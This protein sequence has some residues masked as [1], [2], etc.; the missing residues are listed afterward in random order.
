[1]SE[2]TT[3]INDIVTSIIDE[4]DE[5]PYDAQ[6]VAEEISEGE[7]KAPQVDFDADYEAAQQYSVSEIDRTEEGAK[8]A[9]AA[10]APKF[11]LK[12]PENERTEADST[13]DPSD[14]ME[15]AK[16]VNPLIEKQAE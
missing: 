11:E 2:S 6:Q 12:Q 7:I 4:K 10:T 13:G 1:M 8:A 16:E 14:F 3:N 5:K 9:E 15:M